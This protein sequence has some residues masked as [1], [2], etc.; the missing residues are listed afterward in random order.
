M[1]G[2]GRLAGGEEEG[3]GRSTV[4]KVLVM[5]RSGASDHF[6]QPS[7]RVGEIGGHVHMSV[8]SAD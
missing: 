6:V 3:G 7:T 5:R 4:L 8:R 2:R 1:R